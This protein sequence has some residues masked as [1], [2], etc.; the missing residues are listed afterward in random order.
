MKPILRAL[1]VV[2]ATVGLSACLEVKSVITVNKDGT[3][4]IEETAL[5]S[6][7]VKALMGSLG[8]QPAAE[9][10]PNP[11]AGLKDMV[12][13][14]AKAEERAKELGEGVT[15]KSHQEITTPDGKSGVKAVYTVADIGKVKYNAFNSKGKDGGASKPMTFTMQGDTLTAFNPDDEKKDKPD[16][17]APKVP[18]EEMQAQ[19][20]M[21]KPMF[22]GMRMTMQIKGGAGIASSDATHVEGDTV[23]LMDVQFD[24]LMD[25]PEVFGQ[26]MDSADKN[27][28]QA[29]AAEMF[30]GVD[31]IKVEGKKSVTIKLK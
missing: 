9:G 7:Q 18:K 27:L 28:T 26:V 4:T 24:K 6:A 12:P 14:R 23:T 25:K 31:G 19:L 13:D 17:N 8:G 11:A 22:A 15:L 20:A 10:Q 30:K 16:A 21:M 2:A 3:A 29:E 1:F 5:V